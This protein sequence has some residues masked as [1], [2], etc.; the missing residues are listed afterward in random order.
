[1]GFK[2]TFTM[3]RTLVRNF[4]IFTVLTVVCF[5][6]L[7]GILW[8]SD[9]EIEK[10]GDWV[11]Q[12]NN[13]L[14]ASQELSALVEGMLNSQ[15]GYLLSGRKNF[16]DEYEARKRDMSQRI[17][18]LSEL[19]KDNPSQGSRL[20]EMR[21]Y[22]SGL[23]FKLEERARIV[24]P[25][26]SNADLMSGLQTIDSL[27]KNILR[28]QQ[29]MV[30][31]EYSLLQERV[32]QVEVQKN[33]Y[34]TT[35]I[36]GGTFCIAIMLLLN[37]FLLHAQTKRG[38][39]ER[40]LKESE[41]RFAL[42][43]NGANDGIFDWNIDTGAV[44]YS[45]PFFAMLGQDKPSHIGHIDDLKRLLHPE[46]AEKV[47]AYVDQ[48]LRGEISEYSAVF[49]LRHE[50]GR[51]VWVN[52]RAKAI[53]D[54][55]GR[56]H[57]M[58]GAHT[59]ITYLKEQHRRLEEAKLNAEAA[60]QAKTDFL[61]H[62]SHEIR[63]PLTAISGIAEILDRQKTKL[64]DKQRQLVS[65]LLSSTSTLKDL[66]NDVLDFSK[67]ES[68]EITLE[69]KPF[70]GDD[71]FQQVIS[72]TAMN[73]GEKGLKFRVD[74][75][76]LTGL[77]FH[78]DHLRIR[79]ILINLIGNA[80]K[81]TDQGRIDVTATVQPGNAVTAGILRID[82]K[83]TGIGV[84]R[85]SFDLIFERFKQ[86]DSSV[87]RKYGGTGLGLPISRNLARMMGGD[88]VLE[89]EKNK[90]ST[91]TLTLPLDITK[92]AAAHETNAAATRAAAHAIA[93]R[94]MPTTNSE[95]RV[96]M[97]EDYEGNIVVISYF[98]EDMGLPF[99]I[100][101]SGKQAL[102]HWNEQHYDLILMDIQMP[103][104]DGFTATR[105]IRE[106]EARENLPRTPIIG[107]TAHA[108]VGD[109]DKCIEAGMDAYLPKPIIE[110]DLRAAILA[111]LPDSKK[112]A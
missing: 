105:N 80:I 3:D 71:L 85:E 88:I 33:K 19:T 108:L 84:S 8:R 18:E 53:Y 68:G 91:F 56:A 23:T 62:M 6:A 59:D 76:A 1:M 43:A 22:F 104:M 24:R 79:Q 89:S 29:D 52:A 21:G 17:A 37:G 106:T 47:W 110:A 38:A 111:H 51:W 98:L 69:N 4:L 82:V 11:K 14:M 27:R 72:I 109:R 54:D 50:H 39:A 107:M 99:D 42:A 102:D 70:T 77:I 46:D 57:R 28:L 96:L 61:A 97:V 20:G 73:A 16:L 15:R 5:G 26:S 25:T 2:K 36:V 64:D 55:A 67:I 103:E 78:G 63:T 30:N 32:H 10:S 31:E 49:R 35:L 94:P 60:S 81:F 40:Y 7:A 41:D 100:A 95:K 13:T 12:T 112:A 48:Y 44:F 90:G 66:V 58:V 65:T 9:H 86:G 74:T 83:D 34:F 75:D 92:D 101:R 93:K 87:S 45:K